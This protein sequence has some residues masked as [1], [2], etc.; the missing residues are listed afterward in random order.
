MFLFCTEPDVLAGFAPALQ[1]LAER[2][3]TIVGQSYFGD[4]FLRDPRTGEY[5]ILIGSTLELVDTGEVEEH[6]FRERIL[7]NPE[8]VRT[9]LRPDTA[10]ALVRRLGVPIWGEAFIAVPIPALGGSG[11]VATFEKGGLREYLAIVAQSI[12]GPA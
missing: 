8:V 3:T 2:F 11:A 10:A 12:G 4:L 6:A 1:M 5:A 9:L 7:A